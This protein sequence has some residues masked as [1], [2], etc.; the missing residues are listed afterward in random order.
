M[1]PG[2]WVPPDPAGSEAAE[3]RPGRSRGSSTLLGETLERR[4]HAVSRYGRRARVRD[5]VELTSTGTVHV[6]LDVIDDDPFDFEPGQFVGIQAK[7]DRGYRRSPY[8]IMSAPGEERS[9]E[10]LVR[11]V[12]DGPLSRYLGRVRPGDVVAFRGPTGRTMLPPDRT[13][14]IVLLATGVGLAPFLSL[15]N[16]LLGE[17][18]QQ[19]IA[20]YWGLRLIE[21]ICLGEQLEALARA[22]P[23]FSYRIT[24]S[25]PTRGWTGL[26]GRIT[27]SVPPLIG[28]PE[29]KQFY[30]CGNGAMTEEMGMALFSLGVPWPAIYEEPY[31]NRAHR[32]D[33][34]TLEEIM[35]RFRV[36]AE[37]SPVLDP[38]RPLFPLD[39]PLHR[40]PGDR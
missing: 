31:F 14:D 5:A 10:L 19:K 17:G 8:C 6:T 22:H 38:A 4:W 37:V 11:V 18:S 32:A 16:H 13:A 29:G 2:D 1:R 39:A 15:L 20:L 36:D 7:F 28:S 27:E 12:A 34:R 9:F 35:S 40:P 21:D 33:P 25:Q 26:R 23:N 24:L 3:R 30:L